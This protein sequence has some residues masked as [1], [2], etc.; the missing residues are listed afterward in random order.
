MSSAAKAKPVV[1]GVGLAVADGSADDVNAGVGDDEAMGGVGD[2]TGLGLT[3]VDPQAAS[4][5]ATAIK[6]RLR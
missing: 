1:S 6:A 4:S 2:A 3:V 5:S